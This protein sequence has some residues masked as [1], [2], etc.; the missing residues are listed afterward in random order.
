MTEEQLKENISKNIASLRRQKGITQAELAEALNYSDKSVSKWER[1]EGVPDILVIH[2]ISEFFGV[3][4]NDI[5]SEEIVLE[6]EKKKPSLAS[7][8]IIPLLSSG[9]VFLVSSLVFLALKLF[10][11]HVERTWL[12]FILAIPLAC[13][14][15]IVFSAIWWGLRERFI[16]ISALVWTTVLFL[17]LAFEIRTMVFV[18]ITAAIF[19]V[20][21][22]LFFILRHRSKHRKENGT[23]KNKT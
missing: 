18:I 23:S 21:V 17:C 19:Q 11:P 2:R 12:L 9:L 10:A 7:R 14:P 16:C 5:I 20:L 4:V 8:I 6:E 22:I 1:G 13:I 15:L 3:T